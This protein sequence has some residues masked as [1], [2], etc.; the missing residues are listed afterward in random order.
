MI[1]AEY[2]KIYFDTKQSFRQL[3]SFA[4]THYDVYKSS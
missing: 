1:S 3:R 4:L 2:L